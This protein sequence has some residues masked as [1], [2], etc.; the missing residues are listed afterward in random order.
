MHKIDDNL[1]AAYLEGNLNEKEAEMVEQAIDADKD[2]QAI[3]D[4][5]VNI[6]DNLIARKVKANIAASEE[7][8]VC[9]G[10]ERVYH[11]PTPFDAGGASRK[12]GGKKKNLRYIIM[13][14][15]VLVMAGLGIFWILQNSKDLDYNIEDVNYKLEYDN[16]HNLQYNKPD[17]SDLI[18][19]KPDT[20]IVDTPED[21]IKVVSE[22]DDYPVY[23]IVKKH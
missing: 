7:Y 5:W 13:A 8:K 15:S 17:P 18:S 20:I 1:L 3:V 2:L 21:S 14:A 16:Q 4:E 9:A 22:Y 12:K 10:N 11:S 23:I 19:I 6:Q